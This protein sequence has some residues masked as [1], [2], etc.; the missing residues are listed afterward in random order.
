MKK[1]TLLWRFSFL[2]K[3]LIIALMLSGSVSNA[4]CINEAQYPFGG[5]TSN[6][7][8]MYQDIST[9]NYTNEYSLIN[10]LTIGQD[11]EFVIRAGS[12]FGAGTHKYVTV[13]NTS[14]AVI[15]HGP[16]PLLVSDITVASVRVHYSDNV[17]CDFTE[18]CHNSQFRLVDTT[19]L[20]PGC[21][22]VIAPANNATNVPTGTVTFSWT[23]PTTGDPAASY[24]M[25]YG[26]T[27]DAVTNLV[28]NFTTTEAE[29]TLTGF[30]TDFFWQIVP[31][32]TGGSP[33][34]CPIWSFT[35]QEA[36]GYC[37]SASS[38]VYPAAT[39]TPATCDGITENPITT[40]GWA[41]EYSNIN[42]V[43]GQTYVFGSSVATDFITIANATGTTPI[44]YG[45]TPVTWVANVTGVVRMYNHADNQCLE[46]NTGRTRYVICGTP[47][48]DQPSYVSLQWPPTLT[49]EAGENGMVYGQVYA[50]GVTDVAPL[51][52]QGAGIQAWVGI[53]PQGQNTNPGTWTT[54]V[55]ATINPEHVSNNDE[56]MASIGGNLAPGTY[57]YATRFRL[58]NGPFVYGGINASNAGNIWNGTEFNSGV[59][60]VNPI[61]NDYCSGAIAMIVGTD[62]AT[63]S[64]TA[65]NVGGSV[66]STDP[67]PGCDAA[68]FATNGK[69]IWYSVVVPASGNITVETRS[70]GDEDLEDTGVEVYSGTCGALVS[71]GCNGD[72][73]FEDYFSL[74]E[75]ED[76]T[77][78]TTVFVRVWGYNGSAG[79]FDISVYS[80]AVPCTIEA[81][82][83]DDEQMLEEGQTL[84][85]L[86]VEGT[87]LTWYS[88]E[89]LENEIPETTI[90]Q[91]GAVYYV[92]QTEGDCI[93]E[94]LDILVTFV[95][96]CEGLTAPAGN[97]AQDFE[98]GDTLAD[99]DVT[100]EDLTWYA[101]EDMQTVLP[102]T[103]LLV[104]GSTYY[105]TQS[106]ATCESAVLAITVDLVLSTKGFDDASFTY[107]PNPVTSVLNMSY[108]KDMASVSVYNML[109]QE[110]YAK[111]LNATTA[112]VDFSQLA[113]GTYL[114]K[115]TDGEAD[116]TIRIVKR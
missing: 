75:V 45:T 48:A 22:T 89:D 110:V 16:S 53:S 116:K 92:T 101:D 27:A 5:T 40:N 11:Y 6:N 68:G 19:T 21:V 18:D 17:G 94:A 1:I 70:N 64:V 65:S 79:S 52:G 87:D 99:L 91:D 15:A 58:N 39:Y 95:D 88:D 62:F 105:V 33:T 81:P 100:G 71:E 14:N 103:T 28:G 42:V 114:V 113:A 102:E 3:L 2:P 96:P 77:P 43:T 69:D 9:C 73:S 46:Q 60:T 24:N 109:G 56:Y 112:Q 115:V 50:A 83:G 63:G 93:S 98:E 49:V 86:E 82:E 20:A 84:A 72:I 8:G 4:Q 107:Y 51:T 25:Y 44:V 41:S 106:T 26:L 55:L 57:Y 31:V 10:S 61:A 78:G 97:S 108:T 34:G 111:Q 80:E 85:D 36:P 30:D 47:S 90:V 76:L 32:N 67:L 23:A 54:W 29:I 12:T 37:L 38:G 74:L 59:L 13:T 104:D 7:S 66:T 35:T